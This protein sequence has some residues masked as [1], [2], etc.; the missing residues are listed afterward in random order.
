MSNISKKY[1]GINIK[2]CKFLGEGCEGKVYLTPDGY[3]LKI[4]KSKAKWKGE[5]DILKKVEG[6]KYFPKIINSS[7]ICILREYVPGKTIKDYILKNGLSEKLA[8][9]LINLIEEFK[10]L[11]FKRLDIRGEHI[12]VQDDESIMVID[13]R[14]SYTK[15][16]SVP[17]SIMKD[18]EKVGVID[19]FVKVLVGKRLDLAYLWVSAINK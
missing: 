18:L 19:K 4:F 17:I 9:N 15:N 2:K 14:K 6:S 13:P 1:L 5:Y 11:N 8:I 3:A 12:Y 16:V 10:K 7:N